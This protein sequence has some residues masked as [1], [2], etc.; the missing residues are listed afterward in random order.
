MPDFS[1]APLFPGLFLQA[2]FLLFPGRVGRFPP[3]LLPVAGVL[4]VCLHALRD[5]DYTLLLGQLLLAVPMLR[6]A[7]NRP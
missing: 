4:L 7:G 5:A 3:C 2:V 6:L 1:A